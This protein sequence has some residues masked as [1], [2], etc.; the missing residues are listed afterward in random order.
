MNAQPLISIIIITHNRKKI[1][2]EAI[3]SV[4]LQRY[5]HAEVIVI[6]NASTDGTVAWVQE[7]YPSVRVIR[8]EE[9]RGVSGGRNIG[10]RESSGAYIVNLDDD[11]EFAEPTALE[12]IAEIFAQDEQL[13]VVSFRIE[14]YVTRALTFSELPGP[15]L[16]MADREFETSYF[17]GGASVLR[18]TALET[19]GEFEE[20]YMY[21][22]EE[23]EMGYRIIEAEGRIL[24]TPHIVVLH[25]ASAEA[26]PSGRWYQFNLRGRFILTLK[27]L[28]WL[29]ALVHLATWI[30]YIF[31]K[32]L[33]SGN[34]RYFLLGMRDG[35]GLT[36]DLLRRRRPVTWKTIR[37]LQ[38]LYGRVWW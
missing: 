38:S 28:P 14:N 26:R 32:A 16:S 7:H 9:N 6:D 24:F 12:R 2:G 27:N 25:K 37:K 33:F 23:V 19:A 35:L 15:D 13:A 17:L 11:A 1:L 20:S 3:D 5:P 30:V 8:S 10:I 18:R 4:L 22:P 21:G 34:V 36:P 31:I 29:P